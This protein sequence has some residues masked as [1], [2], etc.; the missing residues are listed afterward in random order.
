MGGTHQHSLL[1]THRFAKSSFYGE[2]LRL[3]DT[4]I[5]KWPNRI[6]LK[7]PNVNNKKEREKKKTI[8]LKQGKQN[9]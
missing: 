6:P 2:I 1:D 4:I 5:R 9:V 3:T 7:V 8:Y